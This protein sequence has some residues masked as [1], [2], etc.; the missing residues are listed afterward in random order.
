MA[1]F[2]LKYPIVQV[3]TAGPAGESLAITVT[4]EG[5]GVTGAL[6]LTWDSAEDV[7]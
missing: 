2:N 1:L 6:P 4:N 5:E 7:L 3:P